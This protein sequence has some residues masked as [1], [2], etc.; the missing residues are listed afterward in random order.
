[1]H[2]VAGS[3]ARSGAGEGDGRGNTAVGAA[4]GGERAAGV[5]QGPVPRGPAPATGAGPPLPGCRPMH[6]MSS[7]CGQWYTPRNITRSAIRCCNRKERDV[8]YSR[9][10]G[11]RVRRKEDPRLITGT[12]T[13]VPDIKLPGLL[14]CAILRSPY[15]HARIRGIDTAAALAHPGVVA[16]YTGQDLR[17]L[18]GPMTGGGGEGGDVEEEAAE[19]AAGQTEKEVQW[20]LAV[21]KVRHVGEQV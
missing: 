18:A 13:Y 8:V 7:R 11:A 20:P 12:S 17:K 3:G 15:A 19:A 6:V 21:S 10:V 16:V 14:H 5:C 2:D 4:G 9:Y 1:R